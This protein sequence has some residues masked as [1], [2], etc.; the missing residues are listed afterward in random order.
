MLQQLESP[1]RVR[2]EWLV[3]GTRVA[4]AGGALLA[5]AIDPAE[6]VPWSAYLFGWFFLYS[7]AVLALVWTPVRFVRGW[8]VAVHLGDLAVFLP[9]LIVSPE[10]STSPSVA[11]FIFLVICASLRW[12][13]R[14][15]L[16]TATAAIAAYAG[17][18]L[19]LANVVHTTDFRLNAF[20]SRTVYLILIA[21]LIGYLGTHQHRFQHEIGRLAWWPR[22]LPRDA[23]ELVS[24][25]LRQSSELLRAPRTVLV[26]EEPG[27]GW[28]NLAW[29][30]GDE[31]TWT[32][33]PEATYGSFVLPG[34]ERTSFQA[35][36]VTD[37]GGL[38]LS[39][40]GTGFRRRGCRPINEALRD[41]F[42]MR[43]VQSWPL[44]GE[45]IRG[46]LFC[47]DKRKMRID[48]LVLGEVTAW[49][50]VSRLESFHLQGRLSEA[51]AFEERIRLARDLHD[52]LL[53]SQSGAALQL[54]AARRLLERDPVAGKER[55]AAVQCQLE[56][57][58]L[59]MRTFITRLRPVGRSVT[60][61]TTANLKDRLEELGQ[62]VERQ[63]KIHV[64][65]RLDQ[66]DGLPAEIAEGTYRLIQ[67]GVINAARHADA[68][69]VDVTLSAGREGVCV[70]IADDGRGFPFHGTFDLRALNGLNQGPLTLKER[71]AELDGDLT[72]KSTTRGTELLITLPV[73][74]MAQ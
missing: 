59:E 52:S 53:Q 41:R 8:D 39:L 49:L 34:L 21:A 38:V 3:A 9:L 26:W 23:R 27:E 20:A 28:I 70:T 46:R 51:A 19:Y 68:S 25:I 74:R 5:I 43:A 31:I 13:M 16:W 15:T 45:L 50:A 62:R 55:L 18:N 69:V 1:P 33:E 64:K 73:A 57:D 35:A 22:K 65:F 29:Q 66:I 24:E 14:G 42:N 11:Y 36:D 61:P 17:I 10:G 47:L 44:D 6:Y 32:Q 72:L 63:W 60:R 4:L 12:Q 37:D 48:D 30:S 40:A 56:R 67:E 2:L 71:V 58:E 54:L 7:L